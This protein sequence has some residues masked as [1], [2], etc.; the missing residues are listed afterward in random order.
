[1]RFSWL[2]IWPVVLLLLFSSNGFSGE[3][4]SSSI[5]ELMPQ[6]T[7]YPQLY[8]PFASKSY[9]STPIST[10]TATRTATATGTAI[11]TSTATHIATMTPMATLC[12][13]ATPE[14][15]WVEAVTSPTD[16]LHQTITVRI[17]NGEA[18]TITTESGVFAVVGNFSTSSPALVDVD[19]L[20]NRIHHL[21]VEAR[22]KV[23]HWGGCLY[24]GYTLSTLTDRFGA[25]LVIVQ[26]SSG[27][28]ATPT[29]TA[30]AT[31]SA[32]GAAPSLPNPTA[33][34]AVSVTGENLVCQQ[35]GATELC[36]WVSEGRPQRY[37]WVT[38]Y[39]RLRQN[40]VAQPGAPVNTFWTYRRDW[41]Y[42][43][44]NTDEDGLA[45]CM[46]TIYQATSGYRVNI[47]VTAG[48]HT[49]TTWFIPR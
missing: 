31:P 7:P 37:T 3:G 11:V 27:S 4:I 39:V 9:F 23:S 32:G 15:L 49:V 10:A 40:G 21:R 2:A 33:T 18:I 36:A 44:A 16:E 30:S 38:V 12:P 17:G 1:M 28:T 45:R 8:L 22:V 46:Q 6:A 26:Q 34:P 47:D 20:P 14:P 13:Q 25:P 5:V 19:L 43:N 24:G 29:A 48:G 42:C 41:A 35:F